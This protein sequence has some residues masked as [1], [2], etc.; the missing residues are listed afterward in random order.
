MEH[1][2]GITKGQYRQIIR[3]LTTVYTKIEGI[4][5]NQITITHNNNARHFGHTAALKDLWEYRATAASEFDDLEVR[6][7][8][9]EEGLKKIKT[10]NTINSIRNKHKLTIMNQRIT[11]LEDEITN[12]TRRLAELNI[13]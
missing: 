12:L 5:S 9:L 10:R 1:K 6:V 11:N 4:L 3:E 13:E 7:H 8:K 2:A